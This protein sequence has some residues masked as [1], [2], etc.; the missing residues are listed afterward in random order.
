[1]VQGKADTQLVWKFPAFTESG[2]SL[3]C[4][5]KPAIKLY[6]NLKY[7]SAKLYYSKTGRAILNLMLH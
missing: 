5:Q 7:I 2:G 1:M 3:L 4:S 6:S